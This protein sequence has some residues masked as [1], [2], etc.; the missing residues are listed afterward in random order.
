MK[1]NPKDVLRRIYETSST[2]APLSA[3]II[4]NLLKTL[5]ADGRYA[6]INEIFRKLDLDRLACSQILLF[7]EDTLYV[8]RKLTDRPAFYDRIVEYFESTEQEE[9]LNVVSLFK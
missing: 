3:A 2:Y 6:D 5:I 4:H 9:A 7:L 8:K 1:E